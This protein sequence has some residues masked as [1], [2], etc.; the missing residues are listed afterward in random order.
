MVKL[1]AGRLV[2]GR[3]RGG[4]GGEHTKGKC[5]ATVDLPGMEGLAISI[6]Q[7]LHLYVLQWCGDLRS[8]QQAAG[9]LEFVA[10]PKL[11]LLRRQALKQA[12]GDDVLDA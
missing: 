7:L 5:I 1:G 11:L 8:I 3:G 9:H 4:G 12:A 10:V 2:G 6:H